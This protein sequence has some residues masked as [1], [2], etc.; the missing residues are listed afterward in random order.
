MT[1]NGEYH[2]LGNNTYQGI[3]KDWF[4]TSNHQ[5]AIKST[6]KNRE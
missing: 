6:H 1:K 3:I 2:Y 4:K 5:A